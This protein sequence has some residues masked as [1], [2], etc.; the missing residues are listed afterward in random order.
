MIYQ[1]QYVFFFTV[2]PGHIIEYMYG[3]VD[4]VVQLNSHTEVRIMIVLPVLSR[5]HSTDL[6]KELNVRLMMSYV[7]GCGMQTTEGVPCF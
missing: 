4:R 1:H 6:H 3:S 5:F 2:F 7:S